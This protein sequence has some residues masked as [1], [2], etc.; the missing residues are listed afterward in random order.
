MGGTQ[1]EGS[2]TD[3][4]RWREKPGNSNKRAPCQPFDASVRLQWQS[5][6]QSSIHTSNCSNGPIRRENA[7]NGVILPFVK[8]RGSSKA[9]GRF[10][11]DIL[12]ASKP[13]HD[14]THAQV[15][16]I[17]SAAEL[18]NDRMDVRISHDA[19]VAQG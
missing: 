14:W 6:I 16:P 10:P 17:R 12:L 4:F 2:A 18:R 9:Q 1:A 8:I 13:E 15:P 7:R 3:A 5:R 19:G 11:R